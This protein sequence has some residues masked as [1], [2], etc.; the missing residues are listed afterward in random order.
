MHVFFRV[1]VINAGLKRFV[2][3]NTA[4]SSSQ[5]LSYCW[6]RLFSVFM[7]TCPETPSLNTGEEFL[8]VC[9]WSTSCPDPKLPSP[10]LWQLKNNRDAKAAT[11]GK[12]NEKANFNCF[13]KHSAGFRNQTETCKLVVQVSEF[14]SPCVGF[15]WAAPITSVRTYSS[16][17]Q[18]MLQA[19]C[20]ERL[21][22]YYI[23][24][25]VEFTRGMQQPSARISV[26]PCP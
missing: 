7:H 26:P 23:K 22:Y 4:A 13:L 14:L 24:R 18:T 6:H 20:S 17:A 1:S 21:P 2:L 10:L 8:C 15:A 16:S 19:L 3:C 9:Y 11:S 25:V 5:M 12:W